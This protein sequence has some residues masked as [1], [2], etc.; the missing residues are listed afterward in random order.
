MIQSVNKYHIYEIFSSDGNF[1][2]T[3]PKY[4]RE[5]TWSYR[6]WES[7]YDDISENNDEYFIGSIICIPLGDTI[8]PYLEVIDGQQRLTTISLFLTAIYTR[9]KDHVK[10]LSEDD[11]DVLPSLRKSLKSKNSP[12][13]MKLV[14]QVQNFNKDDYDYLLN[15]VGLRKA[16]AP[17]HAYYSMRKIARCYTYYLKRLNKEMEGMDGDSAVN[18]LLGKY[19]KVKQA[20]L[21]KIEVSTHSD[22]YVLFES[23]NNRGTPLTAIDL[24]KNLIMAR[25]ESNNLTIDDCFNR[26]QMLL[27]NLSDDYGIQERFFRHYYNAFKHRLNEP[28]QSDNDRKKD[29]LGVV[30]T[31]SNLLN[32]FENLINKDLPSFL[33][34]ILHCGQIYSWLILQDST[35]TTYRKALEDLDHIQGAPSYLL[36]MY[37]MRNKKELAITE[38]HIN[39]LIRLLAKYFVRRNITDY[40]NTRDL[41]RIFMDI[42]SKIEELDSVGNDVMT[43]IVDMLSTP[44]NCASDEQFRRSLEGDVYKDNVGATR[45]IL[46][47]LAESAMTQETWTDLWKRTDKKV[48]VWTIEHIFPEGENIPQCWVDMIANG[49]KSLAQKYLEEYTHKIGNLT[50]TGYNSTLGNKSFEEKRDRKSKDGKRFIGYKNGLEI[51]HEIA[52][53]EMWTIEDIKTRTTDLV[54]KLIEIYEFPGK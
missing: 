22:A 20:M 6:E 51:N 14:P 49:N 16:T 35:E 9:L 21:V 38:N 31:R 18:F 54:N 13:E 48:F 17:K 5:Y 32:I 29:P 8:N 26:W 37:L 39:Q 34:D 45:Y 10:Y 43:L 23:L 28:F 3:I 11:G 27:G 40:P 53:K 41:T 30:A 1:Y 52:T 15:E 47:K 44:S 50:I 4:Q 19:N 42:I 33:D 46:C 7:L 24:M 25:A 12:N 2:Y 36:L